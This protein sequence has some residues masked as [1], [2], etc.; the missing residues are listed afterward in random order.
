MKIFYNTIRIGGEAIP[1]ANI[2]ETPIAD[3]PLIYTVDVVEGDNVYWFASDGQSVK[4]TDFEH[5][6]MGMDKRYYS[7]QYGDTILTDSPIV[8]KCFCQHGIDT[9]TQ[10]ADLQTILRVIE[11][12]TSEPVHF[13]LVDDEGIARRYHR[14]MVEI[15]DK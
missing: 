8:I 9:E 5:S 10:A 15:N 14:V 6:E 12:V 3:R 13:A 2:P 4:P 7:A 11:R 1:T